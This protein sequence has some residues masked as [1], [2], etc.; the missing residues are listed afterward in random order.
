[1]NW[2]GCRHGYG[3]G[4]PVT[5]ETLMD[6]AEEVRQRALESGQPSAAVAI[7]EKGVLSGQKIERKRL[8]RRA[9]LMPAP[10]MSWNARSLSGLRSSVR[11]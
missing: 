8:A 10:T 4:P 3:C 2:A 5:A 11:E 9:N 1:M 7:K 6:E